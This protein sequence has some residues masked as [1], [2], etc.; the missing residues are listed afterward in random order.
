[1][2]VPPGSNRRGVDFADTGGDPL[3]WSESM[4][5]SR[6]RGTGSVYLKDDP[7]N[8]GQKL[9]TWW[10]SYY[11]DGKRKRESSKSRLPRSLESAVARWTTRFRELHAACLAGLRLAP[12]S[13]TALDP[14][15]CSPRDGRSTSPRLSGGMGSNPSR[16]AARRD[17]WRRTLSACRI[18][19]SRF[20]PV[21]VFLRGE[22]P[23]GSTGPPL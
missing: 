3:N 10:I 1:V 9:Q 11:I 23:A 5:R 8:P 13:R 14:D 12:R 17:S 7:N 2:S 22:W 4:A 16:R 18:T 21:E 15:A 6:E 19:R 20:P